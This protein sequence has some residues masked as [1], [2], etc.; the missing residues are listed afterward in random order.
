MVRALQAPALAGAAIRDA[1]GARCAG[2][3]ASKECL[4]NRNVSAIALLSVV[5]LAGRTASA[6][7]S[8]T[9]T[10]PLPSYNNSYSQSYWLGNSTL[11]A[12]AV[13]EAH[14]TATGAPKTAAVGGSL[15][16]YGYIFGGMTSLARLAGSVAPADNTSQTRYSF[17]ANILGTDLYN[18]SG[19]GSITANPSWDRQ[20]INGNWSWSSGAVDLHAAFN[21]NGS[22][23][24]T[25]NA[26]ALGLGGSVIFTPSANLSAHGEATVGLL[27]APL[28]GCLVQVG[29]GIDANV[30]H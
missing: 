8:C 25:I 24:L 5:S 4:V 29:A 21:V 14:F 6:N 2:C 12:Q 22:A 18:A 13:A 19:P 11:G 3:F 10:T 30:L 20:F 1:L 28:V 27:C 9:Q 17:V 15:Q 26:G 7:T 16:A 23:G